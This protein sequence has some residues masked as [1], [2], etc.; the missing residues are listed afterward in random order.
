MLLFF[1][2]TVLARLAAQDAVLQK[3]LDSLLT[4]NFKPNEPGLA[5]LM[6]RKGTIIYQKA[7][8][9]ANLELDV[10]LQ[11]DMVF[12]IGSITKPFTAIGILQLVEQGKMSL[13]DS[14]QKFIPGFPY[15]GHVL[16]IEHLLTHTSGLK[17]YTTIDHP[18]HFIE[19]HDHK[20]PFIIDHF[21]KTPL[22]FTP[23]TRYNYSN[24]NYALLAFIIEKTSGK[25]Y[26]QFMKENVL[27]RAGLKNTGYYVERNIVP[28]RVTGYTRDEG[29]YENTYYQT[30]SLGFGAGDLLST[31]PDLL[32]WNTA[33]WSGKLIKKETLQQAITPC[34]LS[35]GQLTNY[36]YGWLL[37]SLYGRRCIWHAGQ[38][39]GF[40]CFQWYFPDEDIYA[41]LFT[42]VKSGEDK[43]EFSS[44]RFKLFFDIPFYAFNN[45]APGEI[46]LN[47]DQLDRHTGQYEKDGNKVKI[48]REKNRLYLELGGLFPLHPVSEN[49]FMASGVRIPT[50]IEFTK[51]NTGKT[52]GALVW[53]NG[54]YA[55]KKTQ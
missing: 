14:V 11:P 53:Q 34:K 39:S 43:T 45:K 13:Q 40:I 25:T 15:K 32:A 19:R 30:T 29:F 33:L 38:V 1:C 16:T 50:W 12:R 37:D 55:W 49:R 4:A 21:K 22:E 3:S 10:A 26:H 36:G 8:G 31:L 2:L 23:G 42:N 20:P 47:N 46:I 44:N 5:V 51:D 41:A 48:V 27:N 18:D 6:A 17:D 35:N 24:S 54:I 28:K 7:F 9:S 52:T